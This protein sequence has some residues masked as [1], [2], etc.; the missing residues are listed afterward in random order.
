MEKDLRTV[1]VVPRYVKLIAIVFI[2]LLNFYFVYSGIL[3]SRGK[4]HKWQV[5][6][7]SAFLLNLLID[8]MYNGVLEVLIIY[9]IIP[10]SI[11]DRTNLLRKKLDSIVSELTESEEAG[12]NFRKVI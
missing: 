2:V 9:Y 11:V 7:V 4:D 10:M 8:V 3:Y 12:S 1:L 6:W 5:T